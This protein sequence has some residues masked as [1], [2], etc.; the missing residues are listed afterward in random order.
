MLLAAAPMV[1]EA[2]STVDAEGGR[3]LGRILAVAASLVVEQVPLL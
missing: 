3:A 1:E 2:E